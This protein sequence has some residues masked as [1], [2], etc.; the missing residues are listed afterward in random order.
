[1]EQAKFQ[2]LFSK[3]RQQT[4]NLYATVSFKDT[5]EAHLKL[6][7]RAME[8]KDYTLAVTEYQLV[9]E[10]DPN[11]TEARNALLRA[12]QRASSAKGSVP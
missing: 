12:Q 7:R 6:A 8:L 1:M 4:R 10:R 11:L 5:A 2:D 3:G 9:L